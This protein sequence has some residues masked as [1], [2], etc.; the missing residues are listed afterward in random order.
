M[1][2]IR[3]RCLKTERGRPFLDVSTDAA[4]VVISTSGGG[5]VTGADVALARTLHEMTGRYLA[6]CERLHAERIAAA[7]STHRAGQSAS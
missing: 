6:E 7:D 2:H 1:P 4:S 3:V 5:P